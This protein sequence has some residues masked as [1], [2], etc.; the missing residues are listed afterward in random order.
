MNQ[1]YRHQKEPVDLQLQT[2]IITGD[3]HVSGLEL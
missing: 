1:D 3:T 2:M